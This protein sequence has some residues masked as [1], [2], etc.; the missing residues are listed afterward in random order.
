[1]GDYKV[2]GMEYEKMVENKFNIWVF[3][4]SKYEDVVDLLEKVGNFYKF[5]KF[6]E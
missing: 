1:M 3:F 4:G 2:K 5:F 6:C